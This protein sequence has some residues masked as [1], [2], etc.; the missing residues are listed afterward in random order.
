MIG[1]N[2]IPLE[3]NGKAGLIADKN[4]RIVFC[5]SIAMNVISILLISLIFKNPSL[6]DYLVDKSDEI[7]IAELSKIYEVEKNSDLLEIKKNILADTGETAET[8]VPFKEAYF[9][10]K[11]RFSQWNGIIFATM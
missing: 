6:K 11:Y 1:T 3:E 8:A 9:S 2:I 4:W 10:R 7:A 5:Y